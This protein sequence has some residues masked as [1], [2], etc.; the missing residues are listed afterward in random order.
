MVKLLK[1]AIITEWKKYLN[2]SFI[3][4]IFN[5]W[6]RACLEKVECG[7]KND[8]EHVEHCN[9]ACIAFIKH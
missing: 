3:D 4:S 5:E 8:S 9:T 2:V 6:C 1:R 7:G